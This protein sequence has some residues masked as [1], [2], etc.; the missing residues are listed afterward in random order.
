MLLSLALI[1]LCGL[2]LGGIFWKLHLPQLLGMLLT[3][4]L[5]GPYVLNLLDSSILGISADLRQIALIII[6]TRAGL[7]LDLEDLKKVGRPAALLCFVPAAFE[8]AGMLLL[9]PRLLGISLLEAAVMGTVVAAV[10]PAV[11][12]PG[13]LKLMEEGYGTQKSIPQMIMAGASVDDVFVI[14]LFT[15]FTGLAGG[16]GISAWDFVR[17]PVSIL[18]GLAGGILCGMLLVVFFRKVHMRDSVKVIII[19]SLSFLL[20]TLEHALTGIVGFSGL[21]AVMSM[22]I[23]LQKG[24]KEAA[25]RLSAKYS[26]LWVAAELLLFVLVGAAVDIPYAFRAGAA[27]AAVILGVLVFRML[28]V[29]ICLL[30]TELNRK[31]KLFCMFAYMPKATVQ[32]A[33]G[34]VPLA[35]G[36]ACGN[37]VLTVAVL[38]ILI[39]APT[40]AFLIDFTYKR[41]LSK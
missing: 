10:S 15:S 23:A 36:L 5:L 24:R 20:V 2:A 27:A 38:A 34:S 4:I 25:V 35:M 41:F 8:I 6:L 33:I 21:L 12:V 11:V 17:I 29:L 7:N 16:G 13:M 39:T 32:A 28:G 31:E 22:G 37:I 30:G 40:G 18:L 14:V 1:F 3:G 26:K 19:L 9:A